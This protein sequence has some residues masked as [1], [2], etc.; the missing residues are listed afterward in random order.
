[1][2]ILLGKEYCKVDPNGRFKFPS[3]LKKLLL[4]VIEEG[5]I[6]KES[7]FDDCLELYPRKA[8]EH[9]LEEK[10]QRL[11][12]YNPEHRLLLRKLSEGNPVEL[13]TN[14][15]LLI[16]GDQKKAKKINKE[17]VLISK[18]DM[19][20][21]WDVETYDNLNR[22]TVDYADLASRLLG[23]ENNIQPQE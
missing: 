19:I 2:A 21:I 3:A 20:E 4:P 5:F 15:R 9:E 17:I 16:P 7:I 11:N 8:F 6:L 13:D 1:M 14:D 22:K 12:Q 10:R 23:Q 18:V